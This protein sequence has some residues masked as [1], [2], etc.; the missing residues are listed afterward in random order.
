MFMVVSCTRSAFL[1]DSGDY[2]GDV[3]WMIPF[4]LIHFSL[5][6][7]TD[8]LAPRNRFKKIPVKCFI[9]EIIFFNT[10]L[11]K[12]LKFNRRT[13]ERPLESPKSTKTYIVPYINGLE[14]GLWISQCIREST[15]VAFLD[16]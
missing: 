13:I 14:M 5:E 16:S 1:F 2:E 9:C 6:R 12:S 15:L 7:S 4:G 3:L 10:V 8:P 11:Y